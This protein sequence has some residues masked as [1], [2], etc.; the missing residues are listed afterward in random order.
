[1][2]APHIGDLVEK[3]TT[4]AGSA[5]KPA[6]YRKRVLNRL[7]PIILPYEPDTWA[8]FSYANFNGRTFTDDVMGVQLSL[9]TNAALGDDVSIPARP[10]KRRVPVLRR[11]QH[12]HV[13]RYGVPTTWLAG[14]ARLP[15]GPPELARE[16]MQAV[17]AN[18]EAAVRRRAHMTRR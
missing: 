16:P 6:E 17:A 10:R 4:L 1:M 13:T 11:A 12:G 2:F 9:M 14:L 18:D 5:A 15:S 3:M 7:I 8:A